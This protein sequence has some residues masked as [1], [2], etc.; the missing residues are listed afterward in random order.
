MSASVSL[1]LNFSEKRMDNSSWDV[2]LCGTLIDCICLFFCANIMDCSVA[3]LGLTPH[4]TH[5]ILCLN[6]KKQLLSS[7][8][9]SL[10]LEILHCFYAGFYF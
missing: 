4:V 9:K 6:D 5:G 8:S 2:A 1:K 10:K 3:V 7:C